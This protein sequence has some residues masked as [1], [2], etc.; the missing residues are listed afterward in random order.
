MQ[1]VMISGTVDVGPSSG[2]TPN[3][4]IIDIPILPPFVYDPTLGADL[5]IEVQAPVSSFQAMPPMACSNSQGPH[6]AV[7]IQA[8]FG[9]VSGTITDFAN[10]VLFDV[11]GGPGGVPEIARA[12]SE[13]YGVSCNG[14]R[15]RSFAQLFP[16]SESV[17][18]LGTGFTMTPDV[19]GAPTRYHVTAGAGAFVAPTN[20]PLPTASTPANGVTLGQDFSSE[21][22]FP[23]VGGST[24]VVHVATTGYVI[25]GPTTTPGADR[26]PSLHEMTT[27]TFSDTHAGTPRLFPV[28][29]SFDASRNRTLNPLAGVYC[30]V[31]AVNDKVLITWLDLG[32]SWVTSTAGTKSFTFQVELSADGTIEVRYH[33]MSPFGDFGSEAFKLVGFT[34]GVPS[35]KPASYDLS[36]GM[37]FWSEATEAPGA[38][39][40]LMVGAV[41]SGNVQLVGVQNAMTTTNIPA[42]PGACINVLSLGHF[43]SGIDL[44]VVGM[45]GCSAYVDPASPAFLRSEFLLG[46]GTLSYYLAIP[47]DT[48]LIGLQIFSQSLAFDA[49]AQNALGAIT[50]NG[51]ALTVGTV[52]AGFF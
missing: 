13:P 44:A 18:D 1:N 41:L 3:D 10:V 9:D 50:S 7:R 4:Y 17:L 22:T 34:P 2:A 16:R 31:D 46:S 25:L 23:F 12:L 38:A 48:Y 43:G 49:A 19:P 52:A 11:S 36:V 20:G 35:L 37:P 6:K 42:S 5:L 51:L 47:N 39:M 15:T 26:W 14:N 28:W 8:P 40:P 32:E 24:G 27:V 45:P 33:A 30:D 21:F 29:Y